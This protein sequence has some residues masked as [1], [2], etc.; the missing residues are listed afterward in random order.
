MGNAQVDA[1]FD[2]LSRLMVHHD[3][4]AFPPIA[5]SGGCCPTAARQSR[6]SARSEARTNDLDGPP[7]H[8]RRQLDAPARASPYLVC[9]GH[10]REALLARILGPPPIAAGR[11]LPEW[12]ELLEPQSKVTWHLIGLAKYGGTSEE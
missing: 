3:S 9:S 6:W 5:P 10:I 8:T 12:I 4:F 2:P 1:G 11:V 7:R